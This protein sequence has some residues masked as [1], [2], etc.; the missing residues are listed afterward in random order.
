MI[1][2]MMLVG[3]RR[4]AKAAFTPADWFL[5]GEQ[6]IW[7]RSIDFS[8]LFQDSAGTT[9]VTAVE[10]PGGMILDKR[11]GAERGPDVIN[12]GFDTDTAWA[13]TAGATISGGR[14][15]FAGNDDVRQNH[16]ETLVVGDWVEIK[17]ELVSRV[18]GY[19][20]P[21]VAGV[22]LTDG[23]YTPAP[24]I[25]R[26]IYKITSVT[27]QSVG[28]LTAFGPDQIVADNFS[29]RK[30]PGNHATQATT[31]QK[32]A[33]SARVNR[34]LQSESLT[35][36][37]WGARNQ[38]T[39]SASGSMTKIT[40]NAVNDAHVLAQGSVLPT[41]AAVKSFS[42]EAKADTLSWMTIYSSSGMYDAWFNLATGVVGTV[43][44]GATASMV[45]LGN[46]VYRCKIVMPADTD[47]T[48]AFGPTTSDGVRAYAGSGTGAILV[49]KA[50]TQVGDHTTYQRVTT[51]TDYDTV[52]F[53]HYFKLDRVDDN[54]T[55]ATG[56]GSTTGIL[57]CAAIRAGGAGNARTIWSDQGT[58]TGYRLSVNATNQLVL[59]AGS[60]TTFTE[61]IGPTITEGTDY[62]VTGWHDNANINVQVNA[63]AATSAAFGTATAGTAGFT[64]GKDNGAATGYYGERI[65]E[66]VYR[67]D[68]TS[69]A[70]ER[71][72]LITYMAAQADITL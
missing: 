20:C 72:N 62:V 19:L 42:V 68:D 58:N 36:A 25:Y 29:L 66:I 37:V 4:G 2:G 56:G 41:V 17:F 3:Q 64:I 54:V 24:G 16:P 14:A 49:N 32:P 59:S 51:A 38:I 28:L 15:R 46:G 11:F 26:Y 70:S 45:A 67:K 23:Y 57:I 33:L 8:T 35:D 10:Q 1:S 50:H 39:L 22:I 34:F 65:Y 9:P 40:D 61:V 71:T 30:L 55:A 48:F 12:G 5:A 21:V 7:Y 69:T 52:G 47:H 27:D 31:A 63:G 44:N 18:A 53:P 43:R 13:K 60:G 6:G